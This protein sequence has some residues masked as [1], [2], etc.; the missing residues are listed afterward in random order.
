MGA[1]DF[2]IYNDLNIDMSFIKSFMNVKYRGPNDTVF[3]T[4]S[5]N[6]LNNLNQVTQPIVY[7]NLTKDEI[8]TYKQYNFMLAYHRLCINDISYNGSQPFTD[9]ISN[10]IS[11]YNE[12]MARPQRNL[13][14]N[15]E[16][17][18]Y[19]ALK[20]SNGFTDKDLAS[21]CDVEIILPLYIK[22]NVTKNSQLALIDTIN[23]IEGDFAFILTENI[24]T[25]QLSSVNV[26]AV[27][28]FIGIKPLYYI[29]N[30]SNNLYMFISE[31][32]GLPDNV[33]KNASY[34]ISHVIPG[35]IWSFQN[36]F[37]F[38]EYFSF[39]RYNNLDNCTINTADPDTLNSVYTRLQ[40]LMTDS[41]IS[42]YTSSN[43]PVG[44]LLSGGFDSS[45]IVSIVV[46]YLV[47]INNDFVN[48]P[49]HIFTV[50]DSLGSDDLDSNYATDFVKYIETKYNI[51]LYHHIIHINSIEILTSD[52]NDI[53]YTL[54]TY[55]PKV[56]RDSIPFYYLLRYIKQ[57]TNVQVLLTGDGIDE[58]CGYNQFKDLDYQTFQNKSVELL[59]NLYK[60]DLIRTDRI[61]SKFSLEIRQPYLNK[62]FVEYVLSIHPKL[63]NEERYS[64]IEEPIT[65][66]ILRNAFNSNIIGEEI[67]P[68]SVLWRP[69]QCLGQCLTNFEVR[70]INF[71]NA[72]MSDADYNTSVNLLVNDNQKT[73]TLPTTKEQ[74]F[75]RLIFRKY[76]PNRD[77][78][79]DKFW[80]N[81]WLQ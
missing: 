29:K 19:T 32:K 15:G 51:I 16:I 66:Y 45:L 79:V 41:I 60:Y 52:L 8:R 38:I 20:D 50:G 30:I 44:I 42:R 28:D 36:N 1:I 59:Q 6:D 13:L 26:Y 46:K 4:L 67:L 75:Y 40:Q 25:F 39:N 78:L 2:M 71:F 69:V 49:L 27:R 77:Y 80:D 70:L 48:N 81:I 17:Y 22:F 54:E 23:T 76:F 58:L 73:S 65:K 37:D 72:S 35:T 57:N 10:K 7:A 33:I 53:I 64:L 61:S 55:E 14:C 63:K 24:N 74:L 34:N 11:K 68:D 12:L 5:T 43:R 31:I 47:S 9:P 62:Q 21:I 3:I 18:N 56:V